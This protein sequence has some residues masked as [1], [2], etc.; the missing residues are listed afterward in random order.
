MHPIWLNNRV[1]CN[2]FGN[3]YAVF[4]VRKHVQY[5]AESRWRE[6][7]HTFVPNSSIDSIEKQKKLENHFYKKYLAEIKAR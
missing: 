1:F 4:D 5:D 6:N 2:T 7:S 3:R